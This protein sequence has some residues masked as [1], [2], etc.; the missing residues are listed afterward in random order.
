MNYDNDKPSSVETLEGYI[1]DKV[2]SW[3]E[4]FDSNYQEKFD[5]YNR[6]WRGIWSAEDKTRESERSKLISPALQQAVESA[7]AEVEEAT[8]GRGKWFDIKDDLGDADT[9]D[10]G[11]LREKLTEDFAFLVLVK[12][13]SSVSFS[14]R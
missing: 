11:Y 9:K 3:R 10:V 1:M 6:L 13:K 5:E 4:H 12:A 8:F 7:V 2:D 14:L